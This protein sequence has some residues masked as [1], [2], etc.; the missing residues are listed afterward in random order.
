MST[1]KCSKPIII[2]D[3]LNKLITEHL[4]VDDS[5]NLLL[6]N[7]P[8]YL[9][10][11][12]NKYF[13][14]IFIEK[15]LNNFY[16]LSKI[17]GIKDI[18]KTK[19]EY[20]VL[21]KIYNTFKYHYYIHFSDIL[22]FLCKRPLL[23]RSTDYIF[24]III[25]NCHI[26]TSKYL[27][28][29]LMHSTVLHLLK[30]YNNQSIVL[31]NIYI[32]IETL[33]EVIIFKSPYQTSK[34]FCQNIINVNK[35]IKYMLFKHFFYSSNTYPIYFENILTNIS[36]HFIKTNNI[37]SLEY[38]FGY[39]HLYKFKLNYQRLINTC[40]EYPKS[41]VISIVYKQMNKQGTEEFAPVI[42]KKEYITNL[43]KHK[44][45]KIIEQIITLYLGDNI[46]IN[47]N[48]PIYF[49]EILKL[50]DKNNKDCV[51][52]SFYFLEEYKNMLT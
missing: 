5:I 10:Y 23:T 38:L 35:M 3:L 28:N 32:P 24:N 12:N 42:I 1:S 6:V 50:Y 37:I 52:L 39:Y 18:P 45:Y 30:F 19:D 34:K 14:E 44:Q 16:Y 49:K 43:M 8:T 11:K 20:L 15:I 51:R 48:M 29:G 31:E 40:L 25:T 36:C 33:Q 27:Y 46:N 13:Y 17:K 26:S 41:K 7:K 21:N 9:L 47:I 2:Y 22:L 4:N